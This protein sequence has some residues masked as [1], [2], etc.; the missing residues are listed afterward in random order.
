MDAISKALAK[1]TEKERAQIKLI[2]LKLASNQTRALNIAKLKGQ[3]DIYRIRSGKI[4][5]I[6]KYSNNQY[7][8]L[9][10]ERRSDNTYRKY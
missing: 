5:I 8:L 2:L 4:R 7:F 10:V 6:F 9:A 1:L 3:K